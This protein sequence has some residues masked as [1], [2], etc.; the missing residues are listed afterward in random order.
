MYSSLNQPT[1]N[2]SKL[3]R[4]CSTMKKEHCKVL[5]SQILIGVE[6]M[7]SSLNS[8][9]SALNVLL[10]LHGFPPDVWQHVTNLSTCWVYSLAGL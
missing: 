6:T 10:Y 9:F 8:G 4:S 2:L 7:S 5:D 1:N 3:V